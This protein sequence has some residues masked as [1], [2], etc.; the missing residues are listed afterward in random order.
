M[1][2]ED[3]IENQFQTFGSILRREIKIKKRLWNLFKVISSPFME[4]KLKSVIKV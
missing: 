1:K 3:E 2:Q 4:N